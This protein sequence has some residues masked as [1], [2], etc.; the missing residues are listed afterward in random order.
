MVL[1]NPRS[2][3][4]V[5]LIAATTAAALA[6]ID[7][8]DSED[9]CWAILDELAAAAVF[10]DLADDKLEA[11]YALLDRLQDACEQ[12]KLTEATAI[13]RDIEQLVGK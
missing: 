8:I 6:R 11:V 10:A 2:V 12:K 4:I 7:Q 9:K 5:L 3:L 13:S 1:C